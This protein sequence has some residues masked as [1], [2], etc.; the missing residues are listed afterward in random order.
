MK[1][2]STAPEGETSVWIRC[3][4]CGSDRTRLYWDCGTYR[5]QRCLGCGVLYQNPQPVPQDILRRYAEEYY[6]YEL[7][8]EENFFRLM[9]LGLQD[10][11]FDRFESSLPAERRFLDIGCA[12]GRLLEE[13]RAR[14]WNTFGV[15]VCEPSV[16]HARERRGL[17]VHLGTLETAPYPE[18][19]FDAVHFSHV[20]EHVNDPYAFLARV[21]DLLK[22]GGNAFIVT[23]RYTGLQAQLFR[24][25]WRSAIADHLY[26]F[27]KSTL[28]R[29]CHKVGL[30]PVAYRTW[31]GLGV[32]T[33]P[34]WLKR[35][36]DPLAKAWGFGDVMMIRA[37]RP[38]EA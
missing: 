38:R 36:V 25:R 10:V 27:S 29:L 22:P 4:V 12:T 26:L 3:A 15:E 37:R 34:T 18:G 5:F 33:A 13:M 2:F 30:E 11:A 23:P 35:L 28:V 31:G 9:M 8:N 24:T 21:R 7:E 32:G 19:S 1:T 17:E 14:G 6:R 16:R 20:I